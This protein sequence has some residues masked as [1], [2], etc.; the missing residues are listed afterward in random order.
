MKTNVEGSNKLL[1]LGSDYGTIDLVKAAKDRGAYVV[2]ADLMT[3]SPTKKAADE[4]WLI[5]TA[6]IDL[7]EKKCLEENIG[8]IMTGASDFNIAKSRELC[9]R[10]GFPVYCES[11]K[12][13]DIATNKRHFKDICMQVGAP[14]AA[15]YM[16]TDKFTDEELADIKTAVSEAVTNCIIH[17]YEGK[18]R[19]Y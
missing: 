6:D 2:V 16:I 17:G 3:T 10:L 15:D 5:S 12:A 9:K 1:I 19:Y 4:A 18:E 7:L 8:A 11:D 14:I 13:W